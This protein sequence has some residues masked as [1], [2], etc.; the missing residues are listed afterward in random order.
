MP[1]DQIGRALFRDWLLPFEIA[2]VVLLVALIG[3]MVISSAE[4]GEA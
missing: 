4:E 3:A 1:I 2:S